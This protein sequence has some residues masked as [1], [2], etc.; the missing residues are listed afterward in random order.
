M[1]VMYKVT[2]ILTNGRRFPAILTRNYRHAMSINLY[3]GSVWEKEND[4]NAK[5][6]LIKRVYN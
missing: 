3:R 2:G 1:D 4:K 6:K 5:W